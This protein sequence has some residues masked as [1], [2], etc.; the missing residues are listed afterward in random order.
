VTYSIQDL[1][2]ISGFRTEPAD[3][4]DGGVVVGTLRG[5]ATSVPFAWGSSGGLKQLSTLSGASITEARAINNGGVIAGKSNEQVVQ[6]DPLGAISALA[7]PPMPETFAHDIND[8]GLVAGG[9]IQPGPQEHPRVFQAGR[10]S[11]DPT[12]SLGNWDE[13]LGL[14]KANPAV[15]VGTT[16]VGSGPTHAFSWTV[17]GPMVDLTP[18]LAAGS[19]ARAVNLAGDIV[20]E[21]SINAVIFRKSGTQDVIPPLPGFDA[22]SAKDINGP[23]EVVGDSFISVIPTQTSPFLFRAFRRDAGGSTPVSPPEVVDLNTLIPPGS[24][25]VLEHATAINDF[26]WIVGTG[27]LGGSWRGFVLIPPSASGGTGCFGSMVLLVPASVAWLLLPRRR[28]H[29]GR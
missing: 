11:I 26:G 3:I 4:N 10:P 7:P 1:G 5:D 19:A 9:F 25:W 16:A 24:G 14:N 27:Q 20:G 21:S 18:G 23:G 29:K 2:T 12:T 17:G 6:W 28:L 15:V 13:G 22:G 8:A